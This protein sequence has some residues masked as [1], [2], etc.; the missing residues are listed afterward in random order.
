[1]NGEIA[2][3]EVGSFPGKDGK[4]VTTADVV[5][6]GKKYQFYGKR[7]AEKKQGD[8]IEFEVE[9]REGKT[10]KGI[11]KGEEGQKSFKEWKQADPDSMY[12]CNASDKATQ[13]L[14][15]Y[16]GAEV[17][18]IPWVLWDTWFD[19]IY[20]KMAG[21]TPAIIAPKKEDV[22]EF[23]P[24]E[25]PFYDPGVKTENPNRPAEDKQVGAIYTMCAKLRC[26]PPVKVRT[27]LKDANKDINALTYAEAAK[28]IPVLD[29]EVRAIGKG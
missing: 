1:M 20:S 24:P 6:S 29:K 8:I 2:Y 10:P 21:K 18:E 22:P 15:Y 27:I 3:I 25:D 12:R 26:Q 11:L 28:I 16:L 17:K 19:H 5:V 4:P 23:E 14:I 13:I 9:E 7:I